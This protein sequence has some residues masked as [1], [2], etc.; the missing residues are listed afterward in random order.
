[1][2]TV[3]WIRALL[4]GWAVF[5]PLCLHGESPV[6]TSAKEA[7]A[8]ED[9]GRVIQLLEGNPQIAPTE[10]EEVKQALA[11]SH[12]SRGELH[13][14][15]GRIAEC[16]KDFDRVV[17]LIPEQG[18]HH[19]QRGIADYYAGHFVEGV[20]QFEQH[21]TVN[22]EDVENAAWHF[23]CLA[24]APGGSVELA[25]SKLL[26]VH[27]DGRVPMKEIY[28]LYAGKTTPGAVLQAGKEGGDLS[29]F[30]ADLYV[31]L[32]LEIMG[33]EKES[34]QLIARAAVNPK[35][36]HYMGDVARTHLLVREGR[37]DGKP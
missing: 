10:A 23:L 25:R 15:N 18:P 29:R 32:Y 17:E 34:L 24:R 4:S 11:A 13:F 33:K 6:L 22:P 28:K 19:W 37:R 7:L 14:Q 20:E 9:F 3:G 26:P 21:K 36:D 16:L 8:R 27:D 31:G 2:R 35:A 12:Q 1:M 5:L 30:Y